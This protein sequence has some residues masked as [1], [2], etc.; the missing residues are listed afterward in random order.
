MCLM[1]RQL[2]GIIQDMACNRAE[3]SED[4]A[5]ALRVLTLRWAPML[6][7]RFR[8]LALLALAALAGAAAVAA[9]DLNPQPLPPGEQAGVSEDAGAAGLPGENGGGGID[10]G[11]TLVSAD[12]GPS[13][14]PPFAAGDCGEQDASDA[15]GDATEDAADGQADAPNDAG[16]EGGG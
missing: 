2:S 13:G 6:T 9:C 14:T 12:G 16:E 8:T 7:R 3:K 10:S 15:A 5:V 1:G 4:F 11:A